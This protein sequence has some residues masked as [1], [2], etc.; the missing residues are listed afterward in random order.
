MSRLWVLSAVMA[1]DIK[2]VVGSGFVTQG[3]GQ[4]WRIKLYK[5]DYLLFQ[6]WHRRGQT[7]GGFTFNH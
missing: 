5:S 3:S 4:P 1:I 2:I 6:C 7:S